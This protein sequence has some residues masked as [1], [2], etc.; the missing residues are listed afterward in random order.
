MNGIRLVLFPLP[1]VIRLWIE[2]PYAYQSDTYSMK[3]RRDQRAT[4][5]AGGGGGQERG[6][7]DTGESG[8]DEKE[9]GEDGGGGE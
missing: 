4:G 3:G 9:S 2:K 8:G 6:D 7:E 1:A 5:G